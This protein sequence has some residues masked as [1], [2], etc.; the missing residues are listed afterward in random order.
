M[1]RR[2]RT[3]GRTCSQRGADVFATQCDLRDRN[4]VEAMIKRVHDRYRAIDILINNA[5]VIS[6]GPLEEMTIEDFE[7]R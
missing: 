7:K 5:G 3:R 1:S 2:L 4:E 6:V